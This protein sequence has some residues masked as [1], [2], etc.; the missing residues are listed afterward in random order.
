MVVTTTASS[1]GACAYGMTRCGG[2]CVDLNMDTSNCGGCGQVCITGAACNGIWNSGE[3][4]C[5][6]PP[7]HDCGGV[8]VNLNTDPAHCDQCDFSCPAGM[9]CVSGLCTYTGSN[10]CPAGLNICG[11][12]CVNLQTDI[13]NCGYCG[14]ACTNGALCYGGGSHG[15]SSYCS[16]PHALCGGVCVNDQTDNNNCGDCGVVCSGDQTCVAG[17]CTAP[18]TALCGKGQTLCSGGKAGS[19]CVDLNTDS[20]NCGYCG[21]VCIAGGSFCSGGT[22]GYIIT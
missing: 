5:D 22:C 19:V 4:S 15:L 1:G 21:H 8:C 20:N 9:D 16:C 2:T 6:N 17:V 10:P 18:T 13:N 11:G 12:T 7:Y 14:R 3:C